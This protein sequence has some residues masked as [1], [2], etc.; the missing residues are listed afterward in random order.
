MILKIVFESDGSAS[1][2]RSLLTILFIIR[3]KS[4]MVFA[5]IQSVEE[6]LLLY[7]WFQNNLTWVLHRNNSFNV[8]DVLFFLGC[9]LMHPQ[10]MKQNEFR[11]RTC[12]IEKSVVTDETARAAFN[13]STMHSAD[14]E[15]FELY[16]DEEA[17]VE[18][19]FSKMAFSSWKTLNSAMSKAFSTKDEIVATTLWKA[20]SACWNIW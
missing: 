20:F 18:V 7:A 15:V 19:G 5:F 2:K 4:G 8:F 16:T 10:C 1:I 17:E 14:V 6:A 11:R 13:Y 3:R 9:S 12:H